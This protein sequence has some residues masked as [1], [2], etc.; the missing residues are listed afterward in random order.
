MN[1]DTPREIAAAMH[2][3]L[4]QREPGK[5]EAFLPSPM[6]QN[7]AA[8]L[9]PS[10]DGLQCL[11]FGGS[12]EGK[13]DISIWRARLGPDEWSAA[14]QISDDPDRSEQNPVQFDAPDGRRLILHTAQPGGDQDA[15]LLRMREEDQPPREVP[16]PLGTFVRGP[17]HVRSD[18]AWMM[19]LFRCIPREGERWN[20]SYDTAALAISSDA[21]ESWRMVE[22]PKSIGCVHMTLVPLDGARW[23]AFYRRRQADF[24]HRSVSEDD[25]ETWS[26]PAATDLPNNN[27][28]ISAIRLRDGRIAIACNPTNA[29]EHPEARRASLYDELGEADDR[30][31]ASGGCDPIWGVPRAPMVIALSN[32]EGRTFPRRILVEDGTGNCLSNDSLDGRNEEMSYPSLTERKDGTLDLAYSYHRRAIKHVALTRDWMKAQ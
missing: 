30:P 21:G 2:G 8:F 7:H 20:G 1:N 10:L 13:S 19:P 14:E 9:A 26:A 22:V 23:A 25:G 32:D 11:W 17:I 24:V 5:H 18:G 3:G 29:T 12:L 28:S 16:L 15:C 27:S 4:Q 31:N 6:V